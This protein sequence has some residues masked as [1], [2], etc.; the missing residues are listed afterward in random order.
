MIILKKSE[1]GELVYKLT[2]GMKR[3]LRTLID[4]FSAYCPAGLA[5]PVH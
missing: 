3:K 2:K 5:I 1:G 4:T